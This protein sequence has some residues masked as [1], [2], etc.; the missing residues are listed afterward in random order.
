VKFTNLN[1]KELV[2]LFYWLLKK[3]G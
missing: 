1:N 2:K 3:D